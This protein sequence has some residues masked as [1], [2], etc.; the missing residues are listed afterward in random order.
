MRRTLYDHVAGA[1]LSLI[2]LMP[3]FSHA[4]G[5]KGHEITAYVAEIHLTEQARKK[6]K[7]L[8]PKESDLVD[9]ATWPDRVGRLIDDMDPFHFVNFPRGATTYNRQRDCPEHNCIIGAIAWYKR[10]LVNKEAPLNIRRIAFRFVVHLI[11]D[12]HQPLHAAYGDDRG[13]NSIDIRFHSTETNLHSLW[14]I[15]FLETELSSSADIAKKINQSISFKERQSWQDGN[16]V[17]WAE[18]SFALARSHAY[19]VP[20]TGEIDD[21]YT[22]TALSIIYRRLAQAGIRLAWALNGLFK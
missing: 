1:I 16:P 19:K 4:W 11:G 5:D 15:A 21:E 17:A 14:D 3:S 6:I 7:V 18:E 2:L 8:F 20:E 10:T 12:I 9:A 13:G 22:K